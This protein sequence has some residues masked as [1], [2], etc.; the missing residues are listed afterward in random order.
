MTFLNRVLTDPTATPPTATIYQLRV[1]GID[2]AMRLRSGGVV[3]MEE[4]DGARI[5]E[6]ECKGGERGDWKIVVVRCEDY[7]EK[8]G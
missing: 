6:R 7:R 8:D 3:G 1:A 2:R 4:W 5:G